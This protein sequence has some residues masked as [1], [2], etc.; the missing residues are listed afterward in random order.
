VAEVAAVAVGAGVAGEDHAADLRLVAGVADH[1]A[2]LAN[3][4]GELAVVAI[5]ALPGLLP[6]VA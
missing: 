1:W 5:G 6:L 2:E 4:V 3:A